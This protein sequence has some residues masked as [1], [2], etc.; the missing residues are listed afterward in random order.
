MMH[1]D[2]FKQA[3]H[4]AAGYVR[5][6]DGIQWPSNFDIKLF[7]SKET[8]PVRA[9]FS[10]YRED[11]SSADVPL[12]PLNCCR[13]LVPASGPWGP[14]NQTGPSGAE[15]TSAFNTYAFHILV[16]RLPVAQPKGTHE[17]FP[18]DDPQDSKMVDKAVGILLAQAERKARRDL[19]NESNVDDGL[20]ERLLTDTADD[21]AVAGWD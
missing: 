3:L 20:L 9:C 18:H 15:L 16:G 21:I 10:R 4:T 7:S 1:M 12:A 11:L 2:N 17:D 19:S 8:T 6:D 13:M 5:A 14:D